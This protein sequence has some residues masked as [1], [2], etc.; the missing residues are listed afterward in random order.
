MPLGSLVGI[1][2]KAGQCGFCRLVKAAFQRTWVLDKQAPDVDLTEII[3][4]LF[5]MECGCLKDP[6][7]PMRELCHRIFILPSDRPQRIYDIMLAAQS[8]LT[9]DI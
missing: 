8:G 9:L 6:A 5:A 2:E 3:C 1:L 4:S 7:P